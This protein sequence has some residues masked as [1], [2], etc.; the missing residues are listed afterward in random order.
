MPKANI[1]TPGC[2]GPGEEISPKLQDE[3][4]EAASKY[5]I[6]KADTPEKIDMIS[7]IVGYSK[8]PGPT[9]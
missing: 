1:K 6:D 3:I 5:F 9:Q 7:K 4:D 2:H 8:C